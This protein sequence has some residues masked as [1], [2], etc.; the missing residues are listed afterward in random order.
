MDYAAIQIVHI[1]IFVI[2]IITIIESAHYAS[3]ERKSNYKNAIW[4][5]V[6]PYSNPFLVILFH[7]REKL[8]LNIWEC[9]FVFL[10][11]LLCLGCC[12][13]FY[14]TFNTKKPFQPLVEFS[15]SL[16]RLFN[17]FSEFFYYLFKDNAEE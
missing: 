9:I 3:I 5:M 2:L 7:A 8:G 13:F 15:Y 11:I 1:V 14:Y 12:F 16:K 17:K 4:L 6:L 10:I